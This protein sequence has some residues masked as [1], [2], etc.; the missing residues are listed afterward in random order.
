MSAQLKKIDWEAV[1]KLASIQCTA[2]EI[3]EFLGIDDKTL[4]R[5]CRREKKEKIG[6]YIARKRLNGY[7]ALRRKQ[8]T[9]AMDGNPSMLIW[10]GKNWLGQKDKSDEEIESENKAKTIEIIRATGIN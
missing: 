10:L 1:D 6:N 5:A 4:A 8:Y 2:V 7:A 3:S 9:V